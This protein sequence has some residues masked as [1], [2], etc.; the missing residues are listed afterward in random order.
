MI[1]D[2]ILKY[3]FFLGQQEKL[4]ILNFLLLFE[5][6]LTLYG[7]ANMQITTLLISVGNLLQ[8]HISPITPDIEV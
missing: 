6:L 2:Y 4:I 8:G 7:S 3:C 1:Q 5:S